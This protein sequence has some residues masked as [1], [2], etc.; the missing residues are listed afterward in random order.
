MTA[1]KR[2]KKRSIG[3]DTPIPGGGS[4]P[5]ESATTRREN[6]RT[7][8]DRTGCL[9][10]VM[11][12]GA[13]L[14]L[15]N[16]GYN[17][18]WLDEA[19]TL[20]F[21]RQTLAGIWESTATGEFNPP[22]FYWLEHGM[23]FFGESEF[24][25][26]LLPALFGVLTIP[27]V[28]LIGKEFRDRDVGLIAA[29]L[30]A[31]SPFHIFYSQEARAYAPMLFFFS[32]A[33]LF[34]VRASRSDEVRSWVLFGLFSAAAFWMHFYA[35]VPVAVL[36]LHAL[37]TRA[38]TIRSA[39]NPA[40]SAVAFVAASLPLLIVTFGLFRAR[41]SSAPTFGMQGIEIVYQTLFQASG[42]SDLVLVPF[43]LL[44]LLGVAY[45]RREDR[46]GA[47]LLLL[48]LI[49]PLAAS[50]ALSSRMPMI[51]RYLIY[52]LPVYFVGIASAYPGLY[53]LVRDRRA[54]YLAVAAAALISTPFL[55]T[56]YTTPQK[57]DWRGFS[58]EL[59]GMT[60][61]EDL[62]VVLPP[63][64]AQPL[65]YYYSN[66]TDRT[67]EIGATTGDDLA[68]IRG[69]YPGRRAFY[70]MTPDL[71]AANPPGDAMDWVEENTQCY[72]QYTEIY[73]FVS[74]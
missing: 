21:A 58:A 31:F 70:V 63:Y 16:L 62:V 22:L 40:L 41:T 19:A 11:G 45:T 20:T 35:I 73:L 14:R 74:A 36:I 3:P 46:E 61:D 9:L 25:L 17:S 30:L 18:L 69:R 7:P 32:L 26:R 15:Y 43:I 48:M 6:D 51:P 49:L 64:V 72:G 47:L 4:T 44:F 34:Y 59:Y 65:D 57:N 27:V 68:A 71:F 24:V 54:V 1:A 38:G 29:A 66:A 42:S 5:R 13:L 2:E 53:A 37:A 60:G 56:Y 52:L 39:R 8:P 12:I 55:A 28:Y 33:L 50:L 23:L 10:V 67:L